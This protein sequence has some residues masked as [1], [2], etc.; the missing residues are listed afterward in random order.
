M[1]N[2]LRAHR[3]VQVAPALL[4]SDAVASKRRKYVAPNHALMY[5]EPLHIVRGS[6]TWL[7]DNE[8]NEY[9]DCANN[10]AHVGHSNPKVVSTHGV[11]LTLKSLCS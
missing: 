2:F 4:D 10:V 6:G 8:G 7:Y 1:S 11:P 5:N 3:N 9:L